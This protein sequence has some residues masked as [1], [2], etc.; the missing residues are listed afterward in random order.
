M[1]LFAFWN[2]EDGFEGS[3][4]LGSPVESV[5]DN[6]VMRVEGYG[7]MCVRPA[8]VTNRKTGEKLL[9]QI[10]LAREEREYSI[11]EARNIGTEK[12]QKLVEKFTR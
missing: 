11:N 4:Y 12:I 9:E 2:H 3:S 6:G 7:K 1:D 5:L 10:L 8:F